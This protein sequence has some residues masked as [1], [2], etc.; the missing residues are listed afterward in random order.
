MTQ[1]EFL[2]IY[3]AISLRWR[4]KDPPDPWFSAAWPPL[5]GLCR[6]A[7]DMVT[8]PYFEYFVCKKQTRINMFNL[9][10]T[11]QIFLDVVIIANGMAMFVRVAESSQ[12]LEEGAKNFCA[13]WD[14]WLFYACK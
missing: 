8:W 10:V 1:D 7:R 2:N 6:T 12:N 5:R 11:F 3:D 14:A 13:S 9:T 4:H